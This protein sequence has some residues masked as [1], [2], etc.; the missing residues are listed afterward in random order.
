MTPIHVLFGTETYNSQD[1]AERTGEAIQGQGLAAEVL[2]MADVEVD[3]LAGCHT[4]LVITSTFGDGEPPSN[5]A[6]LHDALMAGGPALGHLRYAVLGLGDS[7]YPKFCQCAKD[8]DRRLG[9]LGGQRLLARVDC[10]VDFE[11]VFNGWLGQV[12]KLLQHMD[13]SAVSAAAPAAA[14]WEP[15][16]AWEPEAPA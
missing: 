1:L 16:P 13:F 11:G 14:A 5:A 8:F 7:S 3:A 4:L 9:E 15:E 2:D 10:D 6:E 12:L